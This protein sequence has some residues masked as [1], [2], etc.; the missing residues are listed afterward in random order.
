MKIVSSSRGRNALKR[1]SERAL[2]RL[3]RDI[4]TPIADETAAFTGILPVDGGLAH[5]AEFA[6]A[7]LERRTALLKVQLV[8]QY[9][10]EF[11]QSLAE[12]LA[13]YR[14]FADLAERAQA[15]AL[16]RHERARTLAIHDQEV[17]AGWYTRDRD[18]SARELAGQDAW[19]E[20]AALSFKTL[21][22]GLDDVD[23]AKL[24]P[25]LVSHFRGCIAMATAFTVYAK[26]HSTNAPK[27][28][29]FDFLHMTD[30]HFRPGTPQRLRWPIPTAQT[31]TQC[32]DSFTAWSEPRRSRRL[33]IT[34]P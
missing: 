20:A 13:D 33:S 19:S 34:R 24:D 2:T 31:S 26:P 18:M 9:V 3:S 23:D 30:P 16:D 28:T 15:A 21:K 11:D 17:K 6:P 12:L 7:E 22:E 4:A 27:K 14:M 1:Q 25:D 29:N 10:A 5:S 32:Q 8:E